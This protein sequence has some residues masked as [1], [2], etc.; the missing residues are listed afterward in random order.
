MRIYLQLKIVSYKKGTKQ[1]WTKKYKE[2][3]NKL[4]KYE[5]NLLYEN[6]GNWSNSISKPEFIEEEYETVSMFNI[7]LAI[8]KISKNKSENDFDNGIWVEE[9]VIDN[10][11][12]LAHFQ[13]E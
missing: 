3:L 8:I 10:D 7:K 6:Y 12:I 1:V 5:E 4:W 13:Y 2:Y 9:I 11:E